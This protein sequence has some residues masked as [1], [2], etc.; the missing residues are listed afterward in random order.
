MRVV[1]MQP[2][3]LPYRGYFDLV[4]KADVFVVYDDVQYRHRFWQNRNRLLL[5]GQWRWLTVPV[6]VHGRRRQRINQVEIDAG[7]WWRKHLATIRAAYARAPFFGPVYSE[8][9]AVLSAGFERLLPLN[10]ALLASCF[11]LAGTTMPRHVHASDLGVP[12]GGRTEREVAICRALG[13]DE[14]LSGLAARAYMETELWREAGIRLGWHH[15][16]LPPYPSPSYDPAA[17]VL[18]VL[19][20][21]GGGSHAFISGSIAWEP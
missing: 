19:F 10:L 13:A 16:E 21:C 5:R 1:I 9:E 7:P 17:S 3:Y 20:A 18:D 2:Y 8:L 15:P 12:D 4:G 6:R 14:Y 11:A